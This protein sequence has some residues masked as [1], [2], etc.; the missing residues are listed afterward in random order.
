MMV[1]AA[2]AQLVYTNGPI[3]GAV[4]GII[5]DSGKLTSDSFTVSSTTALESVTAGIWN[6]P[7]ASTTSVSWQ[8]GTTGF[9][10]NVA[11]GTSDTTDVFSGIYGDAYFPIYEDS[12]AISGTV[13]PG[14][15]VLTLWH[16]VNTTS[17]SAGWDENNGPSTAMQNAN[18]I[19]SESF[20]IYGV[21]ITPE[22]SSAAM[23]LGM[24]LTSVT[25]AARRRRLRAA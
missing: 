13:G 9:F 5:I 16:A 8:I 11:Y 21:L 4:N 24:A 23:L 18:S 1:S 12:F 22:P 19:G 17:D 20:Q 15:Y 7:G 3:S 10:N 2:N 25:I 14:S 6:S